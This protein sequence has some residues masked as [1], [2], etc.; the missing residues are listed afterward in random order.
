[1]YMEKDKN[2]KEGALVEATQGKENKDCLLEINLSAIMEH[3]CKIKIFAAWKKRL[4]K[5]DLTTF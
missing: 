2:Y 5:I 3:L 4:K 1:M